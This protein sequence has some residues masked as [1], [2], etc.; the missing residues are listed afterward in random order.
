M[1]AA[2]LFMAQVEL[3]LSYFQ[4]TQLSW[5]PA[6]ATSQLKNKTVTLDLG[7]FAKNVLIQDLEFLAFLLIL[8][9]EFHENFEQIKEASQLKIK[10]ITDMNY[11]LFIC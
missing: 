5:A 10:T 3:L 11:P 2:A 1:E 8:R 9:V 4:L 6:P 7:G